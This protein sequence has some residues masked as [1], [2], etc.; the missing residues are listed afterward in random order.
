MEGEGRN[1]RHRPPRLPEY[2]YAT[3][4]Y[5]F[6]TFNT[7]VRGQDVLGRILPVAPA[8]LG[9]H[10]VSL[11]PAGELVQKLIG[12][13]PHV[14]PDVQVD[15]FVIMPDHVHIIVVL[16]HQDGPPRAAGTTATSLGR[17][18]NAIKALSTKQYG[19]P[20]WQEGYYDHIIRNDLDLDETR[21][22]IRDNPVR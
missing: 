19:Q 13:I 9:G 11:T 10:T 16:G 15:C 7:R 1:R 12:N 18:I 3:P 20:L 5:Y 17:V 21:Q 22:Y 8:A 4:G 6:V 2:D 14:Y